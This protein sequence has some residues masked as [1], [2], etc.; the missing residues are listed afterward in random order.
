MR[1]SSTRLFQVSIVFIVTLIVA[2]C[3]GTKTKVASEWLSP[4]YTG[5]PMHKFLVVG[6]ADSY[7]G[8]LTYEDRFAEAL[9]A[10]G[11]EAVASYTIL[12]GERKLDRQDLEAAVAEDHFD[13][14][15]VTR[16]L[17]IEEKTTVVPPTTEVVPTYRGGYGYYGY[18]GRSYEVVSHP[19]YT[20]TSE[21]ARVE[22]KLWNGANG[23]LAW[24]IVSETFDKKSPADGIESVIKKLVK[25]LKEAGLLASPG[26]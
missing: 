16:L 21:I 2:S 6:V 26:E 20:R 24:G 4:D 12:P 10:A 3:A 1:E 7:L 14:V 5:G 17:G 13:G 25:K 15:L 18:Y 23:Q 22:T 8:R 11:A 19:G 9:R